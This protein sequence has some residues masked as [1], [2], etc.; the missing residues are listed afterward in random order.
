MQRRDFLGKVIGSAVIQ[1]GALGS[2]FA[3][4]GSGSTA[5]LATPNAE[6]QGQIRRQDQVP[7]MAIGVM[8]GP[9]PDD[10]EPQIARVKELEMSNCFLNLDSWIGKFSASGA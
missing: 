8:I 5:A 1:S 10:P 6:S 3:A 2:A 9:H 7:P 4:A